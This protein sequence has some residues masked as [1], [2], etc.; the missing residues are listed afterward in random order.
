[1]MVLDELC[2]TVPSEIVLMIA[3]KE[4]ANEVW[5]TIATMRLGDDRMKKAMA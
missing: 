2:S 1:M 5:D 3:K 4:T